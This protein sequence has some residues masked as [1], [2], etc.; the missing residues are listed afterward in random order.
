MGAE[1]KRRVVGAVDL[2]AC[3]DRNPR[4]D[5]CRCSPPCAVCGFR[6]HF[7][8]HGPLAGEAPGSR[9]FGHEYVPSTEGDS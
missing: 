4:G 8:I 7:A 6:K 9:P 1:T 2:D 5:T 3:R